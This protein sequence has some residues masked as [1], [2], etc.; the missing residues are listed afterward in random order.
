MANDLE[1]IWSQDDQACILSFENNDLVTS[2]SLLTPVLVSLFTDARANNSDALP[3]SGNLD[4]RGWW[5]DAT[6][7]DKSGDT[8]GS[9]LWLIE[10][11][12]NLESVLADAK[13][14]IEEA[15]QWMIDEGIATT[16][17]VLTEAQGSTLAFRVSITKPGNTTESY[18]F[19]QEWRATV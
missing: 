1:L 12:K 11:A 15:L 17:D 18:K 6:N 13:E 8:V 2:R 5:G 16:I 14:Y 10:R 9:R 3:D 4:Q 19:E 7:L